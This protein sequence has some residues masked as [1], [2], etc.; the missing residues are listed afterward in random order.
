MSNLHFQ[1][2]WAGLRKAGWTFWAIISMEYD[3]LVNV[4]WLKGLQ[5]HHILIEA[6]R[7][8]HYTDPSVSNPEFSYPSHVAA[9]ASDGGLG[10]PS[11]SYE[12]KP[13]KT[14]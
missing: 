14:S 13:A 2:M 11:T 10:P 1:K 8:V 6:G 12:K 4:V 3:S 9:D 7:S 5:K